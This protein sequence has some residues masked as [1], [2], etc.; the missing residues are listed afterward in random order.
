MYSVLRIVGERKELAQLTEP[1]RARAPQGRCETNRVGELVLDLSKSPDWGT[2]LAEAVT[3][4]RAC[5]DLLATIRTRKTIDFALDPPTR[6]EH[7]RAFPFT[8]EFLGLLVK[9]GIE[10]EVTV[11][12]M[13]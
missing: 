1:M 5:A 4:L 8:F 9:L 11:Y 2:N 7:L 6:G 10:L 12:E 3:V 13:T